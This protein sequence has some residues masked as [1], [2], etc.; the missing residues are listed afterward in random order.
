MTTIATTT[1]AIEVE[2]IT[3]ERAEDLLSTA[4]ANRRL[5]DDRV[6]A[7]AKDMMQGRWL[8]ASSMIVLDEGGALIDGQHRLAAVLESGSTQEFI[9]RYDAP[10]GAI[11]VIDSGRSRSAA[12][13]LRIEGYSYTSLISAAARLC[14][15]YPHS[16]KRAK[17][18]TNSEIVQF[19]HD[20]PDLPKFVHEHAPMHA[21]AHGWPSIA[22]LGSIM[23]ITPPAHRAKVEE[24][25][26][27][28]YWL[29]N[30]GKPAKNLVRWL[31]YRSRNATKGGRTDPW[32]MWQ[33]LVKSINDFY[34]G[35]EPEHLRASKKSHERLLHE[36][37]MFKDRSW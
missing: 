27:Q 19:V 13:T 1:T 12:D 32:I 9:V 36:R 11:A 7:Y 30:P 17:G 3:P 5:N 22:M 23:F 4:A 16:G 6:S 25:F 10:A 29:D 26:R 21:H 28:V 35:D 2:S 18:V 20:N 31:Q 33:A 34:A 24:F 37:R 8:P 14:L 15:S